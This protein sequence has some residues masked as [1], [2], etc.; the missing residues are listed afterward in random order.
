LI[1][2][3]V[4]EWLSERLRER[5][6]FIQGLYLFGS[7][8]KGSCTPNDCDLLVLTDCDPDGSDWAELKV[9]LVSIEEQFF[10]RFKI[11]LSIVFATSSEFA[12]LQRFRERA[13][14]FEEIRL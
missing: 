2:I 7:V 3:L 14:P 8:Q 4:T 6:H 10:S 1:S 11:P 5:K 12:T 9:A 13:A